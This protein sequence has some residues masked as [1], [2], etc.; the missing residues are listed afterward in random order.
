MIPGT[1]NAYFVFVESNTSGTGYEFIRRA[2]KKGYRVILI[3]ND[4][5]RYD[6][7]SVS[8]EVIQADTGDL[9][10]ILSICR[11]LNEQAPVAGVM[12]TSEYYV[13]IAAEVAAALHLPGPSAEAVEACR[14]KKLQRRAMIECGL[15]CPRHAHVS[16]VGDLNRISLEY[17]VVVKPVSGS[18]SVGVRF[19]ANATELEAAVHEQLK[20][21][22]TN[23]RGMNSGNGLLVEEYIAGKEYSAEV[24][25]LS[26]LGFTAKHLGSL[27]Y[28]VETGHDFAVD[29][30]E[31]V[32]NKAESAIIAICRYMGLDFGAKHV[33]FRIHNGEIY[34]IEINPRLAGGH[35]PTIME[36]AFSG[37][38][39]I[40][41]II[42]IYTGVRQ[43]ITADRIKY[44]V[45][46]R[47]I[48]PPHDGVLRKTRISDS[49]N[50]DD[51]LDFRMYRQ[52]D[53]CVSLH[54]DF[55]DRIGHIIYKSDV[56]PTGLKAA[57]IIEL[58]IE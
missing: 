58:T 35:I 14:S 46:I 1:K 16:C 9:T 37:E 47:F 26:I 12:S 38:K 19:C 15:A 10:T 34:I 57:D 52:Q 42:D 11:A 27:P 55:R 24:F 39:L 33:E 23:E 56:F 7:R 40:D 30:P 49:V 31:N 53:D 21:G 4:A 28:F 43:D 50:E 51:I 45:S 22:L 8:V 32:R 20:V 3:S 5:T 29:L 2:N 17:P 18:G 48:L 44:P 41:Q 25:G 54:G 36:Y 6:L 13:K